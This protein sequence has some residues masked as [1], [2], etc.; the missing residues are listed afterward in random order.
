MQLLCDK[1][2]AK[3]QGYEYRNKTSYLPPNSSYSD[4]ET[5]EVYRTGEVLPREVY[6][7]P[8]SYRDGLKEE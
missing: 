7:G 2:G 5:T 6:L 4:K 8:E 1:C 3:H